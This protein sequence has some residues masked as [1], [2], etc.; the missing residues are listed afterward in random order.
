[1]ILLCMHRR[2]LCPGRL[3]ALSQH[4]EWF[5]QTGVGTVQLVLTGNVWCNSRK[6]AAVLGWPL[7][8]PADKLLP[9]VLSDSLCS[10]LVISQE[11]DHPNQLATHNSAK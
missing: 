11:V 3:A 2:A 5:V 1:M 10:R 9:Q 8:M 4:C 7:G 6:S